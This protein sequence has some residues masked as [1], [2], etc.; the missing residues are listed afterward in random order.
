MAFYLVSPDLFN[1]LILPVL[2]FLAQVANVC[3][4]TLRIVFLSKGMKY[5]APVIAF[6]EIIIWLLA[7]VGVLNNLSNVSYFLAYAFGFAL[8]TYVGLVIEEKLSIGMVIMRIITTDGTGEAIQQFLQA[9]NYGST[10]LDAKGAR[11]GVKMIISLVNRDD[12]PRITRHIEETNPGA[13][14]SIEDV[15]YVNQGVFR[16]KKQ[17]PFTGF[18]HSL[19]GPRKR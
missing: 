18:I 19:A 15:K 17:N 12:L 9:E 10:I 7:I 8:G 4:E 13:F 11:G 14:F 1:W 16:P 2:I 6:F 5:L 3:M